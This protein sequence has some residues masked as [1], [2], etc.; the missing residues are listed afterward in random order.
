MSK[1]R[2]GDAGFIRFLLDALFTDSQLAKCSFGG[3]PSNFNKQ[4]HR[5]LDSEKMFY[6]KGNDDSVIQCD[7]NS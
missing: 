1:E 7:V 3:T 6:I 2:A 5:A 4:Q